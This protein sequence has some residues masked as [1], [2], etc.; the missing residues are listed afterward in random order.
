MV[1]ASEFSA[2][3]RA[4]RAVIDEMT[5]AFNQ[6]DARRLAGLYAADADLVNVYGTWLRGMSAI[7][8]GLHSMFEHI[9][10]DSMLRTR[11]VQVRFVSSDVAIAH[12][13]NELHDQPAGGNGSSA[14]QLELSLRV[15]RKDGKDWRVAAFHNTIR[16]DH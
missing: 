4:I 3:E 10:K 8:T 7:E 12:V 15:F 16:Q 1:Q 14:P 13:L 6:H 9:I 2:D 5:E 11:E